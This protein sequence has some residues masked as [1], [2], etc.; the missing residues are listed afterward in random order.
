MGGG[1]EFLRTT[2]SGF[3]PHLVQPRP[4]PPASRRPHPGSRLVR[5]ATESQEAADLR[6]RMGRAARGLLVS[7]VIRYRLLTRS[8]DE[9]SCETLSAPEVCRARPPPPSRARN[10]RLDDD[11]SPR[12]RSSERVTGPRSAELAKNGPRNRCPKYSRT[13]GQDKSQKAGDEIGAQGI[14]GQTD[15]TTQ[16]PSHT[17]GVQD[18]S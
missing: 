17:R 6:R 15:R 13:N 11:S 16:Y 7:A 10:R 9:G 2:G 3:D 1:T 4:S 8:A 18:S 5:H 12:S 14:R